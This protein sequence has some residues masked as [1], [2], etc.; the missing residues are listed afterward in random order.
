MLVAK[1]GLPM[2]WFR[3]ARVEISRSPDFRMGW[4]NNHYCPGDDLIF[5]AKAISDWGKTY[6]TA[7][8]IFVAPHGPSVELRSARASSLKLTSSALRWIFSHLW[9]RH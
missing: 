3:E 5:T 4:V 2:A 9:G 8:T 6:E 1:A 7:T